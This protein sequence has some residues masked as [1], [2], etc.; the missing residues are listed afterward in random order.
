VVALG[1]IVTDTAV[2]VSYRT[3]QHM[4][5]GQRKFSCYCPA[6]A[7]YGTVT[8]RTTTAGTMEIT[9]MGVTRNAVGTCVMGVVPAAV[10]S[11]V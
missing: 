11:V 3:A 10:I 8:A 6:A 7:L 1:F 5:T 4:M 2:I 9:I